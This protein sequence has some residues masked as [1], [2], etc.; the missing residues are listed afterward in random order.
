MHIFSVGINCVSVALNNRIASVT[1]LLCDIREQHLEHTEQLC[2][3]HGGMP[4]YK[5]CV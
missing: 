4:K 5:S 2:G 3:D 1:N